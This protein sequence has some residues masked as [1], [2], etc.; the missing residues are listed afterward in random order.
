MWYLIMHKMCFKSIDAAVEKCK[1]GVVQQVTSHCSKID[2][3][4]VSSNPEIG[5]GE[6]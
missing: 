1:E 4:N 6:I 3:K 5:G 2:G